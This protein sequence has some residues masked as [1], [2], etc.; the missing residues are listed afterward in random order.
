MVKIEIATFIKRIRKVLIGSFLIFLAFPN[1]LYSEDTGEDLIDDNASEKTGEHATASDE[2]KKG[3][4]NQKEKESAHKLTGAL[5]FVSDYRSRGISQ[6]MLQPA[7][8]GELKYSHKTGCYVRLWGSNVDGT[9]HFLNN[10]SL[11]IDFYVGLEKKIAKT[12]F[13]I[14]VGFELYYYPGGRAP[15]PR[16]IRY[17][18]IEFYIVFGYKEFNIQFHN[19]LNDFFGENSFNPPNNW[20]KQRFIRPNGDSWGSIYVEANTIRKK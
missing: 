11:E 16:Q 8:Q 15:V 6:T 18:T 3:S 10:T 9:S 1:L 5:N 13:K 7:V 19:S 2:V 12:D 14:D 17:N 4:D 20:N